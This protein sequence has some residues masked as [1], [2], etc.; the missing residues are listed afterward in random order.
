M[1]NRITR[2]VVG[3]V[4]TALVLLSWCVPALGAEVASLTVRYLQQEE[5]CAGLTVPL[6]RVAELGPEGSYIPTGVFG[7]YPV[8]LNGI[9]TQ[10]EWRNT[11]VT[12]AAYAAA[13]GLEPTHIA[14]TDRQGNGIFSGLSTGLYLIPAQQVESLAGVTVFE[15]FFVVLPGAPSES[16]PA[17]KPLYDVTA[18]PKQTAFT[19]APGELEYRVVKQWKDDTDALRPASVTVEILKNGALH[20]TQTLSAV[21]NWCYRW[22]AP[23]DGSQWRAVEREAPA[24]YTVTVSQQETTLILTNSYTGEDPGKIPG[25]TPETGD[26]RVLWPYVL[27][28]CFSG[29]VLLLLGIRRARI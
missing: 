12:L 9:Q 10:T 20:S 6:F 5:G 27:A 17:G 18:I 19:P 3:L 26:T 2:A 7:E 28:M 25:D 4:M 23:D 22:K 1:N 8:R 13:D 24:G 21:N 16:D 11:A 14:V 15:D 29:A